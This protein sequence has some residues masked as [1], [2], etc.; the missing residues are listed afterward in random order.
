MTPGFYPA[1]KSNLL[2]C[3]VRPL[4]AALI[5]RFRV[6]KSRSRRPKPPSRHN[7]PQMGRHR[8]TSPY[9]AGMPPGPQAGHKRPYTARHRGNSSRA[10]PQSQNG[11]LPC[12]GGPSP[13]RLFGGLRHILSLELGAVVLQRQTGLLQTEGF[14]LLGQHFLFRRGEVIEHRLLR[15]VAT[16]QVDLQ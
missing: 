6:Q 16:A 11:P 1:Q 15:A 12:L 9:G 3:P 7:R 5:G 14:H 4:C 10:A 13:H 8:V 2:R